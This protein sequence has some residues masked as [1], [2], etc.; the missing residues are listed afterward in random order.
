MKVYSNS[1]RK[2]I[3]V[4]LNSIHSIKRK[5]L[6][7]HFPQIA[8][9]NFARA[10]KS[11]IDD[12]DVEVFRYKKINH[13]RITSLGIKKL[14][15]Q[16]SVR[17]ET[18]KTRKDALYKSNTQKRKKRQA[19]NNTTI[20]MCKSA[21]VVVDEKEKPKLINL[22]DKY[23]EKNAEP[24]PEFEKSL[25]VKNLSNGIFYS[26]GEIRELMNILK[27]AEAISNK[28]R[29]IGIVFKDN[30]L[31][32]I[33]TINDTLIHWEPT[34][35]AR[36]VKI[37]QETLILSQTIQ[38][39][40]TMY[41]KPDCI[42]IGKGFGMIPRLIK[43]RKSGSIIENKHINDIQNNIAKNNINA[44]N[45]GMV[46]DSAYYVPVNKKG[47][48]LFKEAI[49][50]SKEHKD[51]KA[52]KWFESVKNAN[53]IKSKNYY[54]GFTQKM[55]NMAYLSTI[56]LIEIDY[57]QKQNVEMHL[58]APDGT[59]EALSRVFGPKLKSVRN[60]YGKKLSYNEYDKNGYKK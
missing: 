8:Y 41:V 6:S 15:E 26:S 27:T 11:L 43:A 56:D 35:E 12:G 46:F 40:I 57:L 33:Y 38:N 39:N 9:R 48:E 16:E 14:K 54:Q 2:E 1:T 37:I 59:A 17:N 50:S 55:E 60:Y 20:G 10:L 53:R 31:L 29:L 21:N 58:V 49:I 47:I 18:E 42:V 25:F 44:K 34:E 3:L 22:F 7:F 23:A 52:D 28:S 51:Q 13:V 32:F 4:Y 30:R 36:T 45:L 19:I 24:S 5:D